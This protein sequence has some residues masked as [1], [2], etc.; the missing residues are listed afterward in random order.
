MLIKFLKTTTLTLLVIF[1]FVMVGTP[2]IEAQNSRPNWIYFNKPDF[3]AFV[4]RIITGQGHPIDTS[5]AKVCWAKWCVDFP[6]DEESVI[7]EWETYKNPVAILNANSWGEI[8]SIAVSPLQCTNE[9]L[10]EMD[11]FM[12]LRYWGENRQFQGKNIMCYFVVGY[13]P[14]EEP[15]KLLDFNIDCPEIFLK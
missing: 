8:I 1:S 3:P 15:N 5:G 6:I 11:C 10:G 9:V 12:E 2:Q 14:G 7:V 4:E 13:L